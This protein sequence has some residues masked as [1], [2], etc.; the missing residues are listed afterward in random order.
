MQEH[1][2]NYCGTRNPFNINV[3][4]GVKLTFAG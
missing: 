2:E 3:N 1:F 4:A